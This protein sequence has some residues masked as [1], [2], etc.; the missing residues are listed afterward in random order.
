MHTLCEEVHGELADVLERAVNEGG[1]PVARVRA[2]LRADIDLGSAD[3]ARCRMAYMASS[4]PHLDASSPREQV[5]QARRAADTL[6]QFISTVLPLPGPQAVETT[7]QA[8]WALVH[9]VVAVVVEH[10]GF[11][12]VPRD[13]LIERSHELVIDGI[14][15]ETRSPPAGPRRP[16]GKR[17]AW[18]KDTGHTSHNGR[19]AE[20]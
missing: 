14:G 13:R 9:G 3:P 10:P 4:A 20:A 16:G 11:P 12:F 1:S 19:R 5:A 2:A 8:I 7:R 18:G 15:H 17:A 6:R